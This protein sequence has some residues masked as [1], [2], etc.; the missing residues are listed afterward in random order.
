MNTQQ[1]NL[2]G[3]PDAYGGLSTDGPRGGDTFNAALDMDRLNAQSRRVFELMRDGDWRTLAEIA[4]TTGDPE[5]SV[6]ARL[7]DFRKQKFGGM[8]VD[9]RRRGE[10]GDGIFEYRIDVG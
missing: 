5:A 1:P 10:P 7:R 2:F 6:S 4:A 9:R 8:T 3:A